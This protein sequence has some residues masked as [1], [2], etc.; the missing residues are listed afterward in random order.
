[1]L[2]TLTITSLI[3]T[4]ACSSLHDRE[5]R[6]LLEQMEIAAKQ[7]ALEVQRDRVAAESGEVKAQAALAERYA[8]GRGVEINLEQAVQW[9]QRAAEQGDA[10]SQ[11]RLALLYDYGAGVSADP[12]Q[13]AAW[14][15]KAA[16]QGHVKAQRQMGAMYDYGFGV[17]D[18][19]SLLAGI[20]RGEG[21][22]SLGVA[23]LRRLAIPAHRLFEVRRHAEP[24]LVHHAEIV[25]GVGERLFLH[26]HKRWSLRLAR[27]RMRWI[28]VAIPRRRESRRQLSF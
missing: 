20:Q 15:R 28:R 22:L 8:T 1:M 26:R 5:A 23:S 27:D 7:Q 3:L 13:A 6:A 25:L 24:V 14:L 11:Y 18:G 21:R 10:E 16:E 19:N 4:L 12:A 9:Y 2:R 17:I